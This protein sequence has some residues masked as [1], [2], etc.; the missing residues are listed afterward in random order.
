MIFLDAATTRACLPMATAIEA[1]RLGLG[2][3][4]DVP[5]RAVLAGAA[6]MP[7]RAGEFTGVKVVSLVPGNPAGLV[8]V[9]GPDGN[10]LGLVD[11][12]TLTAIRTG[13]A[14]GLAT[15][16]LAPPGTAVLAMLGAGAMARDQIAAVAAVRTID[17][18]RVWSRV[19]AR[20]QRVADE[21]G[22]KVFATPAEAVNGATI[23]STATPSRTALFADGDLGRTVHLNAVGAFTPEMCE[24][25]SDLVQRAF[26]VVDD[27]EAAAVE[28]GDLIQA[29]V[30]PDCTLADILSGRRSPP[31]GASTLFKSVGIASQ[32]VA[33]GVA[34]IEG[35]HRLGLGREV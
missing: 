19:E 35:A 3:D 25:P 28:A 22:A 34:A 6:F 5:M 14:A 33:A 7:G 12:P 18:I 16:L 23:I 27:L 8:V 15:H 31:S 24:I 30:E 26:V 21:V 9:F 29:G 32:D 13:A 11:G 10:P 4:R 2:D 1:M 20:A 17:E